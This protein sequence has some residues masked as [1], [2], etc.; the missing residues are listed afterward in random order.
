M[1]PKKQGM[2]QFFFKRPRHEG[3]YRDSCS[4][5]QAKPFILG[6]GGG[7]G[8]GEAG[9]AYQQ[10]DEAGISLAVAHKP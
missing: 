1:E 9:G 10:G 6:Y 2:V 4:V 8:G 5:V 7:V 3:S